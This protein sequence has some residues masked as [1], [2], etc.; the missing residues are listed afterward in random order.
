MKWFKKKLY[1]WVKDANDEA[2]SYAMKG[3]GIDKAIGDTGQ[4]NDDPVL[5]FRIFSAQNGLILEFRHYDRKTDRSNTST[6]IVGENQ[7]VSEYV[8]QCL[9]IELM[10]VSR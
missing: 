6:F 2:N 4:V 8:R 9:P 7:D 10:K 1:Q 5:N 3:I